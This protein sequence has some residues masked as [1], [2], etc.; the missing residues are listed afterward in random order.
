MAHCVVAFSFFAAAPKMAFTRFVDF[1]DISRLSI[2]RSLLVFC[3][4]LKA[5]CQEYCQYFFALRQKNG[6]GGTMLLTCYAG[7]RI[8][9]RDSICFPHNKIQ[10]ICDLARPFFDT[11]TSQILK[12]DRENS[13][14]NHWNKKSSSYRQFSKMI[15][16]FLKFT[17]WNNYNNAGCQISSW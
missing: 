8:E 12:L 14:M 13:E 10:L 16:L 7:E 5:N 9:L 6:A 4:Q 17:F 2:S 1:A 15:G 3:L 11:L